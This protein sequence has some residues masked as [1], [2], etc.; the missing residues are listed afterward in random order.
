MAMPTVAINRIA[1]LVS[2][3][4]S[5]TVSAEEKCDKK[6]KTLGPRLY[7]QV[8]KSLDPS[9]N[10]LLFTKFSKVQ[11]EKYTDLL[12]GVIPLQQ[13]CLD[14]SKKK[15]NCDAVSV[16]KILWFYDIEK[17]SEEDDVVLS[18][19]KLE[20]FKKFKILLDR[21]RL[22]GLIDPEK[23]K[24]FYQGIEALKRHF[25]CISSREIH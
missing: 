19:S 5:I 3:F 25:V 10:E 18:L 8:L 1:V 20:G 2:F 14:G 9:R 11:K 13:S 4:L 12:D 15:V 21:F 22:E 7:T 16:E 23:N 17:I 24:S 6:F